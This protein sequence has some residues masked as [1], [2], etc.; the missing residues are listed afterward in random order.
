MPCD[1]LCCICLESGC[2]FLTDCCKNKMHTKCIINWLVYKGEFNCPLCRST[3]MRVPL[4]DLL[5][6]P[7]LEYGLQSSEISNNMNN[8]LRSYN[9]QYHIIIDIPDTRNT[10]MYCFPRSY[11]RYRIRNLSC[12]LTLKHILYLLC[13]PLFYGIL[14]TL[15]NNFYIAK[16]QQYVETD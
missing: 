10:C 6:T 2:T 15:M 3:T 5:T 13:I 16:N 9:T 1:T 8:L 4:N 12:G 7:I 14:F 11:L